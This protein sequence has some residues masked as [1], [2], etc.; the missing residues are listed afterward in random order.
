MRF[1]CQR[2][3]HDRDGDLDSGRRK[4]R[5]DGRAGN[6]VS[7]VARELGGRRD[8]WVAPSRL[9]AQG[10]WWGA[11]VVVVVGM[12]SLGMQLSSQ[13]RLSAVEDR[14]IDLACGKV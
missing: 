1:S 13:Q 9:S 10:P 8:T 11:R 5:A 3:F 6:A 4:R 12:L 14:A 7:V 2:L